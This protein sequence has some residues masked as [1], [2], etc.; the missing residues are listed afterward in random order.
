MLSFSGS[1][2]LEEDHAAARVLAKNGPK[3]QPITDHG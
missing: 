2:H 1:C 3:Q